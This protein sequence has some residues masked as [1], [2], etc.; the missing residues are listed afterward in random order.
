MH[1]AKD[2][3]EKDRCDGK[4]KL[5]C[6]AVPMI[7]PL[8]P[9]PHDSSEN[10]NNVVNMLIA[11]LTDEGE[12]KIDYQC[13]LHN[14]YIKQLEEN[15]KSEDPPSTLS[16]N[17]EEKT[18]WEKRCKE[19][20]QLLAKSESECERLRNTMKKREELFNRIIKKSY[21]CGKILKER[22][23]KLR[24]E[25]QIYDRIR[26]RLREI[27]NE[28][29]IKALT[30][31]GMSRGWSD[32]TIKRAMRLRFTC[33]SVGYQEILDQNFPLPSERTLQRKM[34]GVK[35]NKYI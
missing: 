13:Q 18:D 8:Q 27:F 3:W 21:K 16:V 10:C 14:S 30:N 12:V 15:V 23:R 9:V 19:L 31:Q 25:N 24:K 17:V 32:E 26:I 1:F 5:K 11:S 22:L 29:Q 7:F 2:M 28:D 34:N 20:T 4:R 35:F 33:G 6:N